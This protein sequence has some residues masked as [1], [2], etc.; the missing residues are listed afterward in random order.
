MRWPCEGGYRNL[1]GCPSHSFFVNKEQDQLLR[2]T[3]KGGWGLRALGGGFGGAAVGHRKAA[4]GSSAKS[5]LRKKAGASSGVLL[6][7][8]QQP[9]GGDQEGSQL[10]RPGGCWAHTGSAEADGG[11]RL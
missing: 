4:C 10:H 3:G 5:L 9:R 6:S 7:A 1:R 11:G 8:A 2:E